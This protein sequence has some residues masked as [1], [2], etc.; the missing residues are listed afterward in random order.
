VDPKPAVVQDP[1]PHLAMI[2]PS[3]VPRR[4]D[5]RAATSTAVS[6]QR[7]IGATGTRPQVRGPEHALLKIE[8][9]EQGGRL[10]G[11]QH[12]PAIKAELLQRLGR[13]AEATLAYRQALDLTSSE[14]ERE[15][16]TRRLAEVDPP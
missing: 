10:A 12:R 14:T 15:F 1:N 6:V 4:P 13:T 16:L 9:L 3:S 2:P 5:G 7:H 8:K 11:C